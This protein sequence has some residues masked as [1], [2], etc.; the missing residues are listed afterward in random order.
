MKS[1]AHLHVHTEYSLLDGANRIEPLV[2]AA[3][4]D[5]QKALAITDHGNMFGALEFY[6]ACKKHGVKPVLGCEF[7]VAVESRFRKHSKRNGY[8]HITLLARTQEGYENLLRL[9]SMSYL[10]GL[11]YRP[12]VDMSLLSQYAGGVTCLSG[13]LSGRVND[14][15]LQG[16]DSLAEDMASSLRDLYGAE[17]FWLELQRNGLAIQD[18]ATVGMVQIA[19]RMDCPLVATNDIHYLRD[20]DC[21]FQDT[22]LC[23]NTGSRKDDEDRFRFET[24]HLYVKTGKQMAHVFRDIPGAVEATLDVSEQV[25]VVIP[26]GTPIFPEFDTGQETAAEQLRRLTITGLKH[27]YPEVTREVQ[28]RAEY[29]LGVI[30]SMGYDSYF[31]VVQD[32]VAHARASGIPVGPGRGS[33]AGSIVSYAL[34]I[35]DVEPL[36]HNLLFERFLNAD[37]VGLPDID[38]DFCKERRG[39]VIDY[40]RDRHGDDRVANIMTFGTFGPKAA[41]RAAARVLDVP[42]KETD[43]I[44]KKLSGDSIKES[45]ELDESLTPLLNEHKGLR[46]QATKLE[47][48]VKYAG[49]HASGVV[50]ADR[51]LYELV[52]MARNVQNKVSTV[53]T[54]WDLD[55]CEKRGLVKFDFLGLETLTLIERTQ[56]LIEGRTGCRVEL[57]AIDVEDPKYYETLSR[58]DTEGVFQCYSD[59]MRKMLNEMKPDCFNDIVAALALF[60]PGPLESGIVTQFINRKHGREEVTYI[61][62]DA[63]PYLSNTY[64]TLVY[65]EQIMQLAQVLAGFTLNEADEL[66][67]A[68][69]KKIQ[70]LLDAQGEKFL[71]GCK[72]VNKITEREAS[73][74]WDDILKFGRYGFNLSHSAS[75]AYIAAWTLHL[76]VYHPVEFAAANLTQEMDNT[77][78]LRAFLRDAE[79]HEIT[80]LPPDLRLSGYEFSVVDDHTVR[81][82]LGAVKG[83][84]ATVV[85]EL[86]ETEF[87]ETDDLIEVLS[88]PRHGVVK[89]N[90]VEA[91]ARAGLLDWTG[92]DRGCLVAAADQI[93]KTVRK[94]PGKVQVGLW[95]EEGFDTTPVAYDPE[96]AWSDAERLREERAAYGFYISDHPMKSRRALV[97]NSGAKPVP[98]IHKRGKDGGTYRVGGVITEVDVKVVK[99][100]PNKGK[101]FARMLLEDQDDQIICMVFTKVYDR[102]GDSLLA[103]LEAAT[104]IYIWGRLDKST[105]TTQLMTQGV[106][107]LGGTGESHDFEIEIDDAAHVAPIRALCDAHPGTNLLKICVSDAA[108]NKVLLRTSCGVEITDHFLDSLEDILCQHPSPK[109][110]SQPTLTTA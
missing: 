98:W 24:D 80:V 90:I 49:T 21:D 44:A 4:K 93:V 10:E 50:V 66:R 34:G 51:P 77:D 69:G 62:P 70:E 3:A 57:S 37:R 59:G 106:K 105:E 7:Y 89:K 46:N 42:Y 12:R 78:R 17:N 26:Q 84:G 29:E 97:W 11:S 85:R 91:I 73:D 2:Q 88:A 48:M 25:D 40:V 14:L 107:R 15:I 74:L 35:T 39:E 5:G 75:Y 92:V 54:Q 55:D 95:A 32:F 81:M 68:V 1:F 43:I 6:N 83:L 67:K 76:K 33:A 101:K 109:S 53:V 9:T 23:I 65:Q 58:G 52:P 28:D 103:H 82:G 36:V 22:L 94:G 72:K 110:G 96:E 27:R 38:I 18:R 71:K 41:I 30:G 102:I 60:R 19:K 63:E 108:G 45:E 104:P 56:Q 87:P 20:E 31:L 99:N 16:E 47:G 79:R 100:G 8:N 61:H 13:C 86:K 64:G